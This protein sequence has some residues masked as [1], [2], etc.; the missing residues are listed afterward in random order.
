MLASCKR[1]PYLFLTSTSAI[2]SANK[3]NSLSFSEKQRSIP[4]VAN[5]LN[6]KSIVYFKDIENY[7][8]LENDFITAG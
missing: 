7:Q 6:E 3:K 5:S 4:K 1:I 2:Y 8:R